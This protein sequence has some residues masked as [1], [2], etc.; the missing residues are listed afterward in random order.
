MKN[1]FSFSIALINAISCFAQ[2]DSMYVNGRSL[3]NHANEKVMLNGVNYAVLDDWNFPAN[4]NNGNE[5]LSEIEKTKANTVR[6]QWYNNYGDPSRPA[7]NL[8]QLDSL[9]CR[10]ARFKMIPIVGLWDKT[11]DNDWPS[12]NSTIVNWW[13]QPSVVALFNKHKRYSIINMANEFGYYTYAGGT[14]TDL[15]TYKNNYE[16]AIA[17]LRTAGYKQP[18][19]I[20]AP[21]CGTN[22][23]ALIA[24][25][26]EILNSDPLKNI[27]FSVHAYWISF[28]GNDSTTMAN[29]VQEMVNSNLPFVFGEVA[30]YQSDA[31]PCQYALN[32]TDLL[33]TLE[34]KQMGW[35]A[36]AWTNDECSSRQMSSSGL[37]ANMG[38]YGLDITNNPVYGLSATAIRKNN[39]FNNLNALA[40][41]TLTAKIDCIHHNLQI[42][43]EQNN[44]S[45]IS[46]LQSMDGIDW[47]TAT[48]SN[49][50]PNESGISFNVNTA[51]NMMYYKAVAKS[52][53]GF[54]Q[55]NTCV[56]GNN[57]KLF[58]Y[59]NPA[60]NKII[61]NQNDEY[62]QMEITN[63]QGQKF[64]S[65][66]LSAATKKIVDISV[67]ANGLYYLKFSNAKNRFIK[68]EKLVIKR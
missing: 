56:C 42:K 26:L 31:T 38:A 39:T 55:S 61:I 35:L 3:Y 12:F 45:H 19:M 27:I 37:F 63:M 57:K 50:L 52:A 23:D 41:N 32:Y 65:I 13:L 58:I 9:L 64:V 8:I 47:K 44:F 14:I 62:D 59:P 18:I 48:Q 7:F 49:I 24:T 67:L 30:N 17:S 2:P 15:N 34:Q 51:E 66:P 28:T 21:D 4:M 60:T 36:W 10:S 20:D 40:A 53:S 29:K 6:I 43:F 5:R 46:V 16:T 33:K 54:M 1:I 68:V 25:G 11:C 22:A